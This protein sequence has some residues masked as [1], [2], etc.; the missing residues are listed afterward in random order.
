MTP[1]AGIDPNDHQSE[2]ECDLM[3][4]EHVR[5]VKKTALA[6]RAAGWRVIVPLG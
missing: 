1:V 6:S 2:M 5:V 4:G 3:L